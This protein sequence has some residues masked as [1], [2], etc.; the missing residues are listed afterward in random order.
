MKSPKGA[1][2]TQETAEPHTKILILEHDPI[3]TV[4]LKKELDN[5]VVD[6]TALIVQTEEEFKDALENFAPDVILTDYSRPTFKWDD[7]FHLK[8]KL[9][10][11]VP[12]ILVSGSVDGEEA[13]NLIKTGVTD[14]VFKGRP[15]SLAPKI[16]RALKEAKYYHQT[17]SER[18]TLQKSVANLHAMF[19]N[20]DVGFVFLNTDLK[21]VAV[22]PKSTQWSLRVFGIEL[23]ENDDL[24]AQIIP[25]RLKD[26]E[27]FSNNIL[28]GNEITYEASYP[29]TDGAEM[30]FHINGQPV[31]EDEKVIGICISVT[32]ITI[33]K[34]AEDKI[35]RLNEKLAAANQQL[36]TILDTLPANIAMIDL[37]GKII[38]VDAAWKEFADSNHLLSRAHCVGE[39]YLE[40]CDNA[41]GAEAQDGREMAKGIRAVLS[42]AIGE[43]AI[44]YPCHAPN[45][46]RWFRAEVRPLK[47]NGNTGAVIMHVNISQRRIA[48]EHLQKTLLEISDYKYSLDV[49]NIVSL[50]DEHGII[51]YAND[52]FCKISGYSQEE[53]LGQNHNIISSGLHSLEFYQELWRTISSGKVW[54]NEICNRAKDG[55]LY[56]VTS[57]IV[58]FLCEAGK[59]FQYIAIRTD[60]TDRKEAEE[61]LRK[62]NAN[63]EEKVN[64]RTRE[65]M[66]ANKSLETFSYSVSHDL[67]SPVRSV[68]G[69]ASIITKQYG[70]E[71]NDDM[72]ELFSHIEKSSQRM[73]AIIDDLLALA[74]SG[75]DQLILTDINTKGLFEKVWNSLFFSS[76]TNATFEIT[77]LP[78]VYADKSLLQQVVT[79][80]L[81]NAIKYSSKTESPHI[82]VGCHET[83]DATT[84]FVEDNGA[85]FDMKFYGRLFGAFQRLH[86]T[87]EFEGT[88]VGLTLIKRIIEKHGGEVWAEGKVNHGAT[89]YF[90]LPRLTETTVV[91]VENG[92]HQSK[93]YSVKNALHDE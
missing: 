76:P 29:K 57:T 1:Q 73:N 46:E 66:D 80:L 78:N 91:T 12:F 88:G 68:M 35:N 90:S 49:S 40:V 13:L 58:P 81:S 82:R 4:A 7:A 48:E 26:F 32:D 53:L 20:T 2:Q 69:F 79:N 10:P 34:E 72:K 18:E 51:K 47:K 93:K 15:D 52:N 6:Y 42:G 19:D 11:L 50:T 85:G 59:P 75:K 27:A 36:T 60:I 67:R 23:K 33:R 45:E 30:W 38:A 8:Q 44:E 63:L 74:K 21:V 31:E 55:S 14:C 37:T 70:N 25:E 71:M 89:F 41:T 61:A 64:E 17:Q 5:S 24:R 84:I 28:G 62:L 16:L 65:L 9:A 56:W 43:F 87:N 39:N 92:N 77:E 83:K 54:R 86:G 22:N 3:D